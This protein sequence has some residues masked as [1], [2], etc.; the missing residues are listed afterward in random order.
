MRP[1][2]AERYFW[3][4]PAFM[5]LTP[6]QTDYAAARVVVLPVP[7]D[8]SSSGPSTGAREGPRAIINASQEIEL[9]D[10]ELDCEPAAVGIHTLPD[11]KP[12][13]SSPEEM[14][15][16]VRTVVDA[17]LGD[18]KFVLTL[19]GDHSLTVGAAAAHCA[20]YSGL[21]V[22]YLDAHADLLDEYLGTRCGHGSVARR[23]LEWCPLVQVGI[24]SASPAEVPLV[25]DRRQQGALWLVD[26]C[27]ADAEWIE[28]VVAQLPDQVYVSFDLDALDPSI[29][30]AVDLPEP[31]GL[32]WHEA[33]ALLR[34]VAA[35]RRIVGCDVVELS[36]REGPR[37]CAYLAARLAYRLIGYAA[38][39]GVGRA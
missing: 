12:V 17:L 39:Y 31:G 23:L 13:L 22:L 1:D 34:A 29:M 9:F 20:H 5:S 8:A 11:L 37:A 28:R 3:P 33:L 38:G 7:Y 30:A 36:P 15:E 16:A 18:G 4:P 10:L 27:R 32:L 21:G 24:R 2:L 6:Q 26:D 25:K 19:G 35:R 14:V